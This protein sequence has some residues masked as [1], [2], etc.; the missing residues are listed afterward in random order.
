[1][2]SARKNLHFVGNGTSAPGSDHDILCRRNDTAYFGTRFLDADS[3][4]AQAPKTTRRDDATFTEHAR[5]G[6]LLRCSNSLTRLLSSRQRKEDT[7][8]SCLPCQGATRKLTLTTKPLPWL[9]NASR[10]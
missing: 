6:I 8:C 10:D 2:R 3:P 5:R 1:M 4:K 9:R 7:M